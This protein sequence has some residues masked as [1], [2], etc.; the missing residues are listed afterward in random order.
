MKSLH[1][2]KP[3]TTVE[4]KIEKMAFIKHTS[5]FKAVSKAIR[6]LFFSLPSSMKTKDPCKVVE[7]I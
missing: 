7:R 4:E 6:T 5:V 2:N 3:G 1:T